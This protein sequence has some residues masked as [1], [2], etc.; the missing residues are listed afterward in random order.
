[1]NTNLQLPVSYEDKV[2]LTFK[3][4]VTTK[5]WNESFICTETGLLLGIGPNDE[6]TKSTKA[7][8]VCRYHINDINLNH[9]K[10]NLVF[11]KH[12]VSREFF[13]RSSSDLKEKENCASRSI[14]LPYQFKITDNLS[15]FSKKSTANERIDPKQ[16]FS[17]LEAYIIKEGL[18]N[19]KFQK[20]K[21]LPGS[22]SFEDINH[23]IHLNKT[24]EGDPFQLFMM[25][26]KSKESCLF[27]Q[28]YIS[29]CSGEDLEEIADKIKIFIPF[30]ITHRNG[31]FFLQR[32]LIESQAIF[33]LVVNIAQ[34]NFEELLMNMFSSRVLQLVIEKS[35]SFCKFALSYFKNNLKISL[36][37]KSACHLIV[38]CIKNIKDVRRIEFLHAF[39]RKNPF[40]LGN[41]FYH[42]ILIAYIETASD[43][44]VQELAFTM[45]A[46]KDICKLL[47]NKTSSYMVI[48][49]LVGKLCR[50]I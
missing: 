4:P 17:V 21:N 49:H 23:Q 18:L 7:A 28:T 37:S 42:R 22:Y 13:M 6:S 1:M 5:H 2:T 32:L 9:H 48:H 20:E 41:K 11:R 46:H 31:N 29:D 12:L 8:Q 38:S 19:E 39:V 16:L 45:G 25:A 36:Y 47:E 44:Q 24:K 43:S 3:A 10:Q 34:E 26:T 14:D 40:H 33:Q 50:I 35:E 15:S 27:L 30:L